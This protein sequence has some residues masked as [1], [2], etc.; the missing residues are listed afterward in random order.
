[1]IASV[2]CLAPACLGMSAQAAPTSAFPYE[3]A[4]SSP[5]S[6]GS[7]P[8]SAAFSPNGQLLATADYLA[9]GLSVFTVNGTVLTAA[10]GSP[11]ASGNGPDALAFN[12]TGTLLATA[13]L[14]DGTV[15]M[16]SVNTSSGVLTPVTGSPFGTGEQ[17]DLNGL[18]PMPRS[19]AFSPDGTLL[20]VA[21]SEDDTISIFAVDS[22][23]NLTEIS[24]SP[25]ATGSDPVSVTFSPNGSLL[26]VANSEDGTVSIFSVGQS[27]TLTPVSGSPFSTGNGPASVAF[28][29]NGSLLAV[30][31][32]TDGT[33]S[34][35][36]VASGGSLSP[37]SGSPFPTAAGPL[38]VAFSTDGSMLSSAD[39]A[40]GSV[41]V[42]RVDPSTGALTP[43]PGSPYAVGNGPHSAAFSSLGQ[44]IAVAN[45]ADSTVAVLEP[46]PPTATI[47]T[48]AS[49]AYFLEGSKV[50]TRFSC[51]EAPNGPGVGSCTD[52]NGIRSGHGRIATQKIG[53]HTYQVTAVSLD[54]L[55]STT[56]LTYTVLAPPVQ[57]KAAK[58]TG[59]SRTGVSGTGATLKCDAGTWTGSPT[60]YD[61]RWS[62][63]GVP[64]T[65]ATQPT[66]VIQKIDEGSTLTCAITASNQVATTRAKPP[67]PVKVRIQPVSGC[68]APTGR[69]SGTGLGLVTLDDPRAAIQAALHTS[70]D[71]RTASTDT[72]CLTPTD[73]E[74]GYPAGKLL[75][76]LP[77]AL[78]T[79]LNGLAIWAATTNPLYSADGIAVGST[80]IAAKARVRDLSL[81][82]D[83]GND[84]Y[85]ASFEHGTLL[86]A[87]ANGLITEIGIAD[88]RV[89]RSKAQRSALLQSLLGA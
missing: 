13:N 40:A 4:S 24:G 76:A 36:S 75:R 79:Q 16:F 58:I 89:T 18:G 25:F 23:G 88:Q 51:A 66:Y 60:T 19:V 77:R 10:S 83:N 78:R 39:S 15:S 21:N 59:A 84:M 41:S 69:L 22:S 73:I 46:A 64:I 34:L 5:F 70:S 27:N 82:T 33:V 28:S 81:T 45:R 85:S 62:R 11:F 71:K 56:N 35:F 80:L 32:S 72:F 87:V 61:Y 57:T 2:A 30:A 26:A 49:G 9:A 37:I 17:I 53:P 31:N 86:L 67:G 68:P 44:L 12:P 38:A 20:A 48:P 42:F 63:N 1:M 52:S 8:V 3:Q 29:P 47:S 6:T 55:S 7:A 54:G 14:A 50:A 74:V 65:Q 43:A